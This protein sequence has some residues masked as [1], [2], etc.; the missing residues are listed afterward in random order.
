MTGWALRLEKCEPARLA[1]RLGPLRL[2]SG[3][4]TCVDAAGFTWVQGPADERLDLVLRSV[5]G[6]ERFAVGADGALRAPGRRLPPPGVRLPR[7]PWRPLTSAL[8]PVAGTTAE[9]ALA[10]PG[11]VPL[12]LERATAPPPGAD[13][14]GALLVR[15]DRFVAWALAA[16]QV[17]L[18][19][20]EVAARADRAEVLV[21]G[22]PLP[23]LPGVR[24]VVDDG[25]AVPSGLCVRP[26]LDATTLRALLALGPGDLALLGLGAG[27]EG[28]AVVERVEAS[29]FVPASRAVARALRGPA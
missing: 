13:A 7:G 11:R 8:T 6:A 4:L 1:A 29:R 3:V 19:R 22:R 26:G 5:A 27:K 16:P 18:D 15:R 12:T 24:F 25:V 21:R 28:P 14:P 17:R 9:V 20:L 10:P 2:R 23:P